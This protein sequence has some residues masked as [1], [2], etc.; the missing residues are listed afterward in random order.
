MQR[1]GDLIR[2]T[3]TVCHQLGEL[4]RRSKSRLDY[5]IYC[6]SP[7]SWEQGDSH[8]IFVDQVLL[9]EPGTR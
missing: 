4:M 7:S 2:Y 6:R 3:G 1:Q 9:S 5:C 8:T